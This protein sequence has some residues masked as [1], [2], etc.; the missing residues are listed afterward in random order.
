MGQEISFD[1]FFAKVKAAFAKHHLPV[2]E[3]IELIELSHME[4]LEEETP[5]DEFVQGMVEEAG[6]K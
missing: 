5:V 2:P 1:V 3:D 6:G 4:M